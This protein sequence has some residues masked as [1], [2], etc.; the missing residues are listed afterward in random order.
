MMCH[1]GWVTVICYKLLSVFRGVREGQ[2]YCSQKSQPVQVKVMPENHATLEDSLEEFHSEK[3]RMGNVLRIPVMK[4]DAGLLIPGL[5]LFKTLKPF[6][7]YQCL[8]PNA[9]TC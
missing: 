4:L 7:Q 6:P 2:G 9:V 3:M 5:K 8:Y 1:V